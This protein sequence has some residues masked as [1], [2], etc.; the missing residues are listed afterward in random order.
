MNDILRKRLADV[1]KL[2]DVARDLGDRDLYLAHDRQMGR[3]H[4]VACCGSGQAFSV[5]SKRLPTGELNT[6][7]QPRQTPGLSSQHTG[8]TS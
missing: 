4:G 7:Q 8:A 3:I 2:R 5:G 1:A 6:P